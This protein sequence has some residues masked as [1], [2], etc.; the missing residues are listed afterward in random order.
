MSEKITGIIE[1]WADLMPTKNRSIRTACNIG[2]KWFGYFS[3]D[4][5]ELEDLIKEFPAGITVDLEYTTKGNFFNMVSIGKAEK[6][7]EQTTV[8]DAIT[9]KPLLKDDVM[10][11]ILAKVDRIIELVEKNATTEIEPRED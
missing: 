3:R 7:L 10:G 5:K 9:N 11:M 6:Q 4:F 1:K 2:D 8:K